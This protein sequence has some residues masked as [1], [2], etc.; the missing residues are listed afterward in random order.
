M[1]ITTYKRSK[2]IWD[3]YL[4]RAKHFLNNNYPKSEKHFLSL[5]KIFF[6]KY[7]LQFK[8][9]KILNILKEHNDVVDY[10]KVKQ[11]TFYRKLALFVLRNK[12]NYPELYVEKNK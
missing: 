8:E 3:Y 4:P 7:N 11:G 12:L 6:R 1:L 5:T 2:T 10:T 9:E